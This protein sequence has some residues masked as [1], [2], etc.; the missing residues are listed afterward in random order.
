[1]IKGF[2]HVCL[3]A[4][5][6]GAAEAFY[7]DG[8]G[9]RNVFQFLRDGKRFGFYL[10]LA[11]GNFIEIFESEGIDVQAKCPIQ[12]VCIEVDDIDAVARRL[13]DAGY[14]VSEKTLGSD[15]SWQIWTE[16]PSGV[17]IEFHQYTEA[18]SQRTG[19][20]CTWG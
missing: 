20:D 8:L 4:K 3:L 7:C 11:S 12:H 2:A 16:D 6:L 19:R 10:E 1:M 18:S 14:T 9:C 17:K 13:T 15:Q 5:D